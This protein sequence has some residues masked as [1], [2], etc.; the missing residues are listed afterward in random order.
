MH[1]LADCKQTNQDG[2]QFETVI[3]SMEAESPTDLSRCGRGPRH[4]D[5]NA[6]HAGQQTA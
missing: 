5:Q 2:Q 3:E 1:N 6:Q 4:G